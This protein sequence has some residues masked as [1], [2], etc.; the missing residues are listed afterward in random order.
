MRVTFAR[1]HFAERRETC[2]HRDAVGVV[3]PAVKNFVLR[4]QVHHCSARAE[5]TQGQTAAD[6]FRETDHV[7]FHAKVLRGATPPEFR[8]GLYFI[9]YQ[10][11]AILGSN[12][13][14]AL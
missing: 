10:Q 8:A 14:Q 5:C 13:A 12:F 4:D 11:R 2:S 9:E 3:R 1:E 7:R 6:G